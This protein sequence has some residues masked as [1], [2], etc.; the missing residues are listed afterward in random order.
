MFCAVL[1]LKYRIKRVKNEY[2]INKQTNKTKKLECTAYANKS[3]WLKNPKKLSI[4]Q[5][6]QKYLC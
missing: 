1:N 3:V 6:V 5:P 4:I 2:H